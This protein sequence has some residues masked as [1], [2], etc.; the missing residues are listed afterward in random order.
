MASTKTVCEVAPIVR[1][2][3][4]AATSWNTKRVLGACVLGI[5]LGAVLFSEYL[6]LTPNWFQTAA[7]KVIAACCDPATQWMIVVCL[8]IYI[9]TFL[10]LERYQ[11]I[12]T[13]WTWRSRKVWLIAFLALILSRYIFGL[14]A[15][16]RS[17]QIVVLLAGLGFGKAVSAWVRGPGFRRSAMNL[18]LAAAARE[19]KAVVVLF[20][21]GYLTYAAL[22]RPPTLTA[23][24]YHGAARWVGAWHNPNTFGLLMAVGFVLAVGEILQDSRFSIQRLPVNVPD[25]Q[26][27][28]DY[29]RPGWE[30]NLCFFLLSVAAIIC[31]VG[32]FKSY[33][34]GAWVATLCGIIYL[35]WGISDQRSAVRGSKT[36]IRRNWISLSLIFLSVAVMSFWQFRFTEWRPARRLYSMANINDFS[37]RNRLTAWNGTL[38]MMAGRPWFGFGWGEAQVVYERDYRPGHLG[39]PMAIQL[40][41][42]SVLGISAGVPALLCFLIY[43]GLS[44]RQPTLLFPPPRDKARLVDANVREPAVDFE[45]RTLDCSKTVC[46][47]GAVVLSV[48]LWFDGGLFNLATAS[49]LWMLLELGNTELKKKDRKSSTVEEASHAKIRAGEMKMPLSPWL[50]AAA[51]TTASLALVET[52]VLGGAPFLPLSNGTLAIARGWL[53]PPHAIGDFNFLASCP[54]L[55]DQKLGIVV[56]HAGLANYNRQLV[57]WTLDDEMYRDYVLWPDVYHPE[58][59]TQDTERVDGDARRSGM[60]SGDLSWRRALW[61]YF[62]PSMRKENDPL[63]AAKI[64]VKFLHERMEIVTEGPSTIK[65]MWGQRRADSKAFEALKVAAFRSV[66]IPARLN[67]QSRAELFEDGQWRLAPLAEGQ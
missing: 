46:R 27:T 20:L 9:A 3:G 55:R 66:G 47:A 40:N 16:V 25:P 11:T 45:L 4:K 61:E 65:E 36:W 38:H 59:S 28:A 48:G 58:E 12:E 15:P 10:L 56:Q 50:R 62:Y 31:G 35:V 44:L 67:G 14:G 23:D 33:S 32:L 2:S 6:L 29:G 21:L 22:W 7:S 19:K 39:E 51:W 1:A 42:Y 63:S 64:V 30:Q 17:T 13:G 60:P 52:I 26:S 24:Q 34:R 49:V 37:W 53:I 18:S 54:E 41:D 43:I 8:A 57:N 5:S